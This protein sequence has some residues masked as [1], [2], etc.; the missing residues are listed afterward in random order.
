MTSSAGWRVRT[1]FLVKNAKLIGPYKTYFL[2]TT[3]ARRRLDCACAGAAE[4]QGAPDS[5]ARLKGSTRASPA[6]L[7]SRPKNQPQLPG[8]WITEATQV[9]EMCAGCHARAIRSDPPSPHTSHPNS[10]SN[11]WP[12]LDRVSNTCLSNQLLQ[13]SRLCK[14]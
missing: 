8:L 7:E 5:S 1:L 2:T 11:A 6:P 10:A 3:H 14:S 13:A 9:F 4:Q 12:G